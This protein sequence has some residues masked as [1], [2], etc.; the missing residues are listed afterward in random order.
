MR[1]R[2]LGRL[3]LSLLRIWIFHEESLLPDVSILLWT[4]QVALVVKN[5]LTNARDAGSI[6]GLGRYSGEGDGNSLQYSCLEKPMDRGA[7]W[8]IV[9]GVTKSQ[10][11][12]S[13]CMHTYLYYC[14]NFLLSFMKIQV[15]RATYR[16][17]CSFQEVSGSCQKVNCFM[18]GSFLFSIKTVTYMNICIADQ[19]CVV[20]EYDI[21][22]SSSQC[23]KFKY[24][25]A[26]L[27]IY[28]K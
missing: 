12:L 15:Q 7:W 8:T 22:H 14:I 21:S 13:T 9:H 20:I 17:H 26:N 1:E 24:A 2:K 6:P 25:N 19:I 3:F 28:F 11:W 10:M 16:H 4:S 18:M 23:H 5:M 27:C